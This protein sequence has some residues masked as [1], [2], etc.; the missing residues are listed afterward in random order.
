MMKVTSCVRLFATPW[1][2][3]SLP[4]SSVHGILR[5]RILEWVAVPFSRGENGWVATLQADSLPSELP[6]CMC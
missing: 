1:T 6:G 2:V 4:G 3:S 5:A